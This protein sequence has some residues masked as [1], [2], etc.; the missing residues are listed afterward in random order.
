M[1]S[2]PSDVG[3]H[4]FLRVIVMPPVAKRASVEALDLINR[5]IKNK[6]SLSDF[7]RVKIESHL[8]S[9]KRSEIMAYYTVSACY[10]AHIADIENLF[11]CA[12]YVF[13][14]DYDL[15]SAMNILFALYNTCQYEKIVAILKGSG[16]ESLDNHHFIDISVT[17]YSVCDEFG[18]VE[19]I[20]EN[21]D[22]GLLEEK[23]VRNA[24]FFSKRMQENFS[25]NE[26]RAELSQYLLSALSLYGK[27]VGDTY[28]D[29]IGEASLEY[30]F[31]EDEGEKLFDL[32]FTFDSE[33]EDA[34]FDAEDDFLSK[35]SKLNYKPSVRSRVSFSFDSTAGAGNDK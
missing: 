19:S 20:M 5:A 25:S 3:V 21:M 24:F 4:H 30:T 7:E 8:V 18:E 13:S 33:N 35:V 12:D 1:L 31:F 17:A 32:K 27:C 9:A 11:L 14:H 23:I 26:D 6:R 22:S 2:L 28:R 34:I 16:F 10:Y 29:E 15:S